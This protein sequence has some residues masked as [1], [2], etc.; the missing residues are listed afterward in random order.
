MI[1]RKANFLDSKLPK[2]HHRKYESVCLSLDRNETGNQ[3]CRALFPPTVLNFILK[4][5][6][7][8]LD[9]ISLTGEMI[10]AVIGLAR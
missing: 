7:L 8:F 2:L 5:N 9:K 10:P 4:R 3:A 1:A 6:Y